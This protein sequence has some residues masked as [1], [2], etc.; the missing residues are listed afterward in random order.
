MIPHGLLT[1]FLQFDFNDHNPRKRSSK[2]F[3]FLRFSDKNS[4]LFAPPKQT[5]YYAH[6]S[7]TYLISLMIYMKRCVSHENF[8][9]VIFLSFPVIPKPPLPLPRLETHSVCVLY[10][11]WW[12][13]TTCSDWILFNVCH[14]E[15]FNTHINIQRCISQTQQNFIMFIIVL[16]QHVSILIEPSSGPSTIQILT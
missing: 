11:I 5:T 7:S 10:L 2:L 14:P 16:G 13:T 1:Y 12:K 8:N 3:I 9:Y 4:A 15:V 6:L